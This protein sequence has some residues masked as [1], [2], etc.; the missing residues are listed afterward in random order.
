MTLVAAFHTDTD[1]EDPVYHDQAECPYGKEIKRN[2]NDHLG[3]DG[4]R[5]CDW[6]SDNR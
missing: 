2:G 4:R 3:T 5:R 6:C 1:P